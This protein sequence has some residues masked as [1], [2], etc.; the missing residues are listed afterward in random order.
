[1]I[2]MF[3]S[4][5]KNIWLL[6]AS[7]AARISRMIIVMANSHVNGSRDVIADESTNHSVKY[8]DKPLTSTLFE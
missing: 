7:Q 5:L 8:R 3:V 1:M 6:R 4:N 2:I